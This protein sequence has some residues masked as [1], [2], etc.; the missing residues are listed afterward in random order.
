[1]E[2]SLTYLDIGVEAVPDTGHKTAD[3][4]DTEYDLSDE[5]APRT[6]QKTLNPI[7]GASENVENSWNGDGGHFALQKGH[8]WDQCCFQGWRSKVLTGVPLIIL[9][10]SI[11]VQSKMPR[12]KLEQLVA[13]TRR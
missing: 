2:V 10:E 3:T 9:A 4:T 11:K 13:K 8:Y 12:T 6:L 7:P 1:M 5:I